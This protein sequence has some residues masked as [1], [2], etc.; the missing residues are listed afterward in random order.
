[1][2]PCR[3]DDHLG[4]FRKCIDDN[5]NGDDVDEEEENENE[6][7]ENVVVRL[8]W[9]SILFSLSFPSFSFYEYSYESR[10]NIAR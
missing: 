3:A 7:E 10:G 2:P 1:M 9:F 6:N 8:N 4:G 5:D